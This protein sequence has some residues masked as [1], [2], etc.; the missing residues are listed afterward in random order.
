M[1]VIDILRLISV[2]I[3]MIHRLLFILHYYLSE[4]ILSLWLLFRGKKSNILRSRI[5]TCNYDRKQLFFGTVLF[6]ILV[7]LYPTFSVYY[8][9][10]TFLHT[11]IG[12]LISV[13]WAVAVG[14]REFPYFLVAVRLFFP[15]AV[16]HGIRFKFVSTTES[17]YSSDAGGGSV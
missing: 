15:R 9:L 14:L 8:C 4:M 1:L 17:L 13:T 7:F 2:H 16:T 10:F 3:A 12:L 6:S 5:D 11:L